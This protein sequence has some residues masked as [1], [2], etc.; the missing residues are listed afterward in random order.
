M[1]VTQFTPNLNSLRPGSKIWTVK[2]DAGAAAG[3][4]IVFTFDRA[5]GKVPEVLSVVAESSD[6]IIA[7]SVKDVT[8]TTITI[9][10]AP[11]GAAGS[12][13]VVITAMVQGQVN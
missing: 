8:E 11:V 3:A 9:G 6:A 13:D 10:F 5:F 2:E 4:D 12:A 1:A 7:A